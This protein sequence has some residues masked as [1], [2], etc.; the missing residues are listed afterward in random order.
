LT[1]N[2]HFKDGAKDEETDD[3]NYEKELLKSLIANEKD[4]V[5]FQNT[6]NNVA[7]SNT[8]RASSKMC[9]II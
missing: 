9:S 3:K 2:H 5:N 1:I 4:K 7:I 8:H 6:T